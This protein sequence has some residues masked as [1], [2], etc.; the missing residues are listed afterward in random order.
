MPA[1]RGAGKSTNRG[2]NDGGGNSLIFDPLLSAADRLLRILATHLL[3]D[4]KLF[5]RLARRRHDGDPR[6]QRRSRATGGQYGY[7]QES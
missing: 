2:G 1:N 6:P 5:E 3:I 7:C 4:L